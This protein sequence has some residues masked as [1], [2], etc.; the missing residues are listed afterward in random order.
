[1]AGTGLKKCMPRNLAGR[2]EAAASSVMLREEVLDTNTAS[3][4]MTPAIFSKASFFRSMFSTM[5]SKTM[6]TSARSSRVVVAFRWESHSVFWASSILPLAIFLSKFLLM[7]AT[8]FSRV[9]VRWL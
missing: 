9:G 3:G 1:M 2:P 6:S 5:A 4:L 7:P 8:P